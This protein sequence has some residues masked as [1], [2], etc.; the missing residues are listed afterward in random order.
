MDIR[1]LRYFS[2]I[3]EAGSFTKAAERV[4]IAQPAL[5]LQI[6]KLEEELGTVLLVRHSRGVQVTEAGA[7]L[8]RHAG[9]ILQLV[10]DARLEVMDLSGDSARQG[11]RRSDAD[12][13]CPSHHSTGEDQS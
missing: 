10:E 9:S 11:C 5:G 7:L 13:Q 4:R 1:Q 2:A 8:L 12:C 3:A 6:K